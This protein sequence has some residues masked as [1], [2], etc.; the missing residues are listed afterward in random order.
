MPMIASPVSPPALSR[1]TPHCARAAASASRQ[2][3]A[4]HASARFASSSV[5]AARSASPSR[6]RAPMRKSCRY[7]KRRSALPRLSRVL[8]GTSVRVSAAA[9][10]SARHWRMTAG[11]SSQARSCGWRRRVSASIWLEPPAGGGEGEPRA[12][13]P[14]MTSDGRLPCLARTDADR[15]VDRQHEDLAVADGARLRRARDRRDHL[16]DEVLR[17]HDLDLDLREEV[18][19][20]LRPAVQLRVALLAAEAANLGDGHADDADLGERLLHVIE[21][22]RLDDGFHL[23]HLDLLED[24]E[25]QRGYV[26]ADALQVRQHIEVDLG[27]LERLGEPGAQPVQVRLAHLALALPHEGTLI[28]HV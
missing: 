1:G 20:V 11:S 23:L 15:L 14:S 21:L 6:S 10:S 19:R 22:E 28:E 24:G 13:S 9:R 16:L 12:G 5:V 2:A 3:A 17:N 18:D 8:N 7:L 26:G 4:R 25:D 27:G